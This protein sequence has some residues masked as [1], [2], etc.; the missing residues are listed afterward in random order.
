[1]SATNVVVEYF[2]RNDRT[3]PPRAGAREVQEVQPRPG[4]SRD[5]RQAVSCDVSE[6]VRLALDA[7][8]ITPTT[9]AATMGVTLSLFLRQLQNLDNQHVSLQRLYRLP[10]PFWREFAMLVLERRRLAR[11]QRRI[12]F[13]VDASEAGR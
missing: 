8:H 2:Q 10:D 4:S 12:V 3:L 11:V 6:L 7:A 1:M 13:D 9:A 5:T